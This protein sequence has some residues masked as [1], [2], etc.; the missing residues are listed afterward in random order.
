M[1]AQTDAMTNAVI[2]KEVW[3]Q[4]HEWGLGMWQW[5]GS[6]AEEEASS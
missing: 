5:L 6:A 1:Y 2:D 3:E 4:G